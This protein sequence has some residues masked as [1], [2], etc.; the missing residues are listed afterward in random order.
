MSIDFS[1]LRELDIAL[2]TGRDWFAWT[3]RI[4]VRGWKF[5]RSIKT[6]TH[7]GILVRRTGLLEIAEMSPDPKKGPFA[8]LKA[9]SVFSPISKYTKGGF[10]SPRIL[11]FKRLRVYDNEKVRRE[12]NERVKDHVVYGMKYDWVTGQ[13][14]G[15]G[16]GYDYA[17]LLAFCKLCNDNED[18]LYCSE[19]VRWE[20]MQDG[21]L[22]QM[23]P[24]KQISPFDVQMDPNSYPVRGWKKGS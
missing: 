2:T 22:W 16:I 7:A 14:K 12:A 8:P 11:M 19:H 6:A 13:G 23:M 24:P 1:V 4:V 21:V 20:T 5:R 10:F 9:R 18:K 3:E 15:D 17:G